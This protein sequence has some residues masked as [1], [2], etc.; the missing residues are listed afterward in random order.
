MAKYKLLKVNT[1]SVQFECGGVTVMTSKLANLK[2]DPNFHNCILSFEMFVPIKDLYAPP[3]NIRVRDHR[4]FG[5]A[6]IVGVC[7]IPSLV[8]TS[9]PASCNVIDRSTAWHVC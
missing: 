7:S 3:L 9:S 6:P 5:R 1:P 4:K 8:R 2:S